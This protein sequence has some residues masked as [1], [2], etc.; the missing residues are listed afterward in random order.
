VAVLP[1]FEVAGSDYHAK[2]VD[3][4]QLMMSFL[5]G[6]IVLKGQGASEDWQ[7]LEVAACSEIR[8]K[9]AGCNVEGRRAFKT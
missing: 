2:G 8:L 6:P 5:N 3:T 1:K 4:V 7:A 9:V